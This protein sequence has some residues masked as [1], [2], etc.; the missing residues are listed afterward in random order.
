MNALLQ[1]FGEASEYPQQHT[2]TP[3]AEPTKPFSIRLTE[4]KKAYLQQQAGRRPLSAYIR[5]RLLG[6][7]AQKRRELRQP[8]LGDTQ[9][10]SLLAALGE[11]RMSSNINQL[12]KHANMGNLDVSEDVERQL[13]E[14]YN[15]VL[16]MREALFIALG[17]RTGAE[18]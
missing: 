11:S 4:Q 15:A 3:K 13:E 14:A 10:A 12:A 5:D 6:E 16:A 8:Q 1:T 18:K 17:L 7:Q 9:Y 2:T